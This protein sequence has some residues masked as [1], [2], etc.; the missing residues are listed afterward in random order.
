[1]NVLSSGRKWNILHIYMVKIQQ[2]T[3]TLQNINLRVG[4]QHHSF[5]KGDAILKIIRNKN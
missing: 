1:M 4:N 5:Y 2:F 3:K